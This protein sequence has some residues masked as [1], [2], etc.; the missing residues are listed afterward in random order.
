MPRLPEIGSIQLYPQRP[1]RPGDKNG[2]VLKFYCPIR[3]TRIRKNCGTRDRR[4]ARRVLRECR[5]RLLNGEYVASGGAITKAQED[6]IRLLDERPVLRPEVV[7]QDRGKTWEECYERYRL[8]RSTRMREK[9]LIDS[10]SRINLVERILQR[11]QGADELFVQDVMTL[12]VLEGIQDRLLAGE[13]CRYEQR[14]PNTVNSMMA[15]LMA[16][17]RFCHKHGWIEK[18]PPLEKLETG[19]VMKG[20]P[21]TGEEFERLLDA[22]PAVVGP[23]YAAEWQLALSLL[24]E[25]GFRIGELLNFTWDDD[26]KI[27]PVWSDRAGRNH[28]IIVPPSQKNRR[29]QEIPMLPGLCEV[30][31]QIPEYRRRGHVVQL[32]L[33]RTR[34]TKLPVDTVSRTIARIGKEA[35]IV[36]RKANPEEKTRTKFASA[37]DLRRGCAARLINAG[38]SAE[39]LKVV[40]RHA[41]FGTTEKHYGAIRSAQAAGREL[42]EKLNESNSQSALAGGFTGGRNRS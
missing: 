18:V 5:E 7:Q 21:I 17:V 12:D 29:C 10:L 35:G 20:R 8:H 23:E 41:D 30:L 1:L 26:Q 39:T 31:L 22:T 4:T 40:M 33:P 3:K 24:W 42:S 25:S 34:S 11:M 2:F 15:A 13:E 28:T 38:V 16:F 36:V 9:S 32:R 14:S 19:D 6:V 27:H 37:H